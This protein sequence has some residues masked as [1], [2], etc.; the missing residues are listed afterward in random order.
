MKRTMWNIGFVQLLL[1]EIAFQFGAYMTNP[2]ISGYALLLG[3]S[4]AMAGFL[5]SLTATTALVMRPLVGWITD[6]FGMKALLVV[7][8]ALFASASFGCA[9]ARSVALVGVLRVLQGI[10]FA[11][12]STS[13][14]ALVSMV[15]SK[16][17]IGKAVGWTGIGQSVACALGPM[18][19]AAIISSWGY[20][21]SFSAAGVL[22]VCGLA[23]VL[24]FK[25]PQKKHADGRKG[26]AASR[27][28]IHVRDFLYVPNI[29][30]AAI[31]GL[32][33]VPHGIAVTLI[34][35]V[36]QSRGIEGTAIYFAVYSLVAL[37]AKPLSGRITDRGGIGVVLV[38]ALIIEF[39]ATAAMAM[40]S[41]LLT[42]IVAGACMGLG[43]ASAYSAVQAEC[44][45]G[46]D[47]RHLG[48]ATNTFY[49]G[50]DIGMGLGPMAASIVMQA[51]GSRAM[52]IFSGVL[53]II[54]LVVY[55]LH[56]RNRKRNRCL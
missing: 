50:T 36:G 28:G 18:I 27:K 12:R 9:F 29:P 22:F 1:I 3:A 46:V 43:Q 2:V 45:R 26:S 4:V 8:A 35:V 32:L 23:L 20:L 41:H 15:V 5:S 56:S 17:N 42:V 40:M 16:E 31:S 55:F 25:S 7:S 47:E 54:A 49:F 30:L 53:V 39:C 21:A 24:S 33:I 14:I 38:P 13:V 19:G 11:L 34:L 51:F 10:A 37:V 52:F 48:R 6:R 44:V